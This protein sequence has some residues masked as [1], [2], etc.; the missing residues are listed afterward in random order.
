[1]SDIKI[2]ITNLNQ[3]KKALAKSPALMTKNLTTAIKK[4]IF[5]IRAE[6]VREAPVITGR[7]RGSAVNTFS[8]LKGTLEFKAKYAI[9]VHDGTSPYTILPSSKK[10]LYWKGASHPVKRVN[11]P[12][13]RANP[14][15]KRAVENNQETIDKYFLEALDNT[16]ESVAKGAK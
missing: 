3:I 9:W 13:I 7:L 1:M 2:E 15:L 12:G 11:H 10:A 14:F 6:S 16:L 8:T 5:F 4:T